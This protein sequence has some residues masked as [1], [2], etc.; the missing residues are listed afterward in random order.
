[1]KRMLAVMGLCSLAC[2][3]LAQ[4]A[5]A[6]RVNV[7]AYVEGDTVKVEC[8][9]SKSS[10]V[11]FGDIEVSDAA[12]G[13]VLLSGK[14]DDEGNF[15]FRIPDEARQKGFDLRILLRAGEGHQN[16]WTVTAA[17]Y[18][19]APSSPAAASETPATVAPAQPSGPAAA[20][21]VMD[22]AE[23]SAIV[24]AAVEEKIAPLR[25]ILLDQQEKGPGMTEIF[26][27]IGYLLGLAGLL[28]Y[29]R[30]RSIRK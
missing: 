23:L 30:S 14:T 6:H 2:L 20:A 22:K 16:D 4:A 1:M 21:L 10:R 24:E 29:A 28:A 13:K 11:H 15:A 27:G 8:S 17:E 19:N 7:F 26:G 25:R 18:S 12:S 5:A 3:A 9:Y